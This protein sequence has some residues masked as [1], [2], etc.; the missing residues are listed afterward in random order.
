[1]KQ[2]INIIE[3][4]F[5]EKFNFELLEF[6]S[7]ITSELEIPFDLHKDLIQK[8]VKYRRKDKYENFIIFFGMLP[9]CIL[10]LIILYSIFTQ[11]K[12]F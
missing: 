2:K 3:K 11:S 9:V 7:D 4:G 10:I 8:A 1:M 12:H 6:M 5:A